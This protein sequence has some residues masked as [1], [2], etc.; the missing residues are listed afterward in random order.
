MSVRVYDIDAA[1]AEH[2][3]YVR[4]GG[5]RYAIRQHSLGEYL[6]VLRK[7]KQGERE[8][9]SVE[10]I[11]TDSFKRYQANAVQF[12]LEGISEEDAAN[13]TE[14]EVLLVRDVFM[15]LHSADAPRPKVV[16]KE[17]ASETDPSLAT[18]PSTSSLPVASSLSPT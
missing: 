2:A 14:R 8:I 15:G 3:A 11:D 9:L 7:F 10:D 6:Q 4:V 16:P 12:M 13:L 1:L 5:G 17:E 18:P